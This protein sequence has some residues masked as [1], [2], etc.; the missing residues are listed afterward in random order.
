MKSAER[1]AACSRILATGAPV[2]RTTSTSGQDNHCAGKQLSLRQVLV[3]SYQ[4]LLWN[5]IRTGDAVQCVATHSCV[6][7]RKSEWKTVS[8]SL[9]YSSCTHLQATTTHRPGQ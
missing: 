6:A 5:A 3:G 7:L 1:S 8:V 9:R 4:G 2:R